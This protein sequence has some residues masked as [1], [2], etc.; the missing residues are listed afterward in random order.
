MVQSFVDKSHEDMGVVT[1]IMTE[2]QFNDSL[3]FLGPSD[4]PEENKLGK[5]LRIALPEE[6]KYLPMK[7][8]R[9]HPLLRIC[10]TYTVRHSLPMIIHGVEYQFDGNVLFVYYTSRERV[11]F[12]PLVKFLI[13]MYCKG[14]RIQMKKTDQSRDFIP[15]ASA[16][17]ALIT[18]KYVPQK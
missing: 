4:D 6:R 15:N 16:A 1:E 18:G 13:K 8:Q 3:Q 5:L 7:F 9:E 10:Q 2:N 17:E 12:R 14:T 11:D